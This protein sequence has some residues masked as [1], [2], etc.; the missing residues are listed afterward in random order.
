MIRRFV[1]CVVA[2]L[3]LALMFVAVSANAQNTTTYNIVTPYGGGTVTT[4]YRVFSL[5]LADANSNPAQIPWL[6]SG[7]NTSCSGQAPPYIGF[8]FL[9]TPNP[10][11]GQPNNSSTSG[12]CVPITS[13]G[14]GAIQ[15]AGVDDNGR[16]FTGSFTWT[17]TTS[18]YRSSGRVSRTVCSYTVNSGTLTITE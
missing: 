16:S 14:V 10:V 9:K 5:N 12:T 3:V 18:C 15:F 1:C 17:E 13:G 6:E 11:I 4:P 2:P 8:L 7:T